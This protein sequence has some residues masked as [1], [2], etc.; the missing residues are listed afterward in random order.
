MEKIKLLFDVFEGDAI[1]NELLH[2]ADM[3]DDGKQ[4][5]N[6]QQFELSA[7]IEGDVNYEDIILNLKNSFETNKR[8]VSFISIRKMNDEPTNE[9]KPYIKEGVRSISNGRRFDLFN[10]MLAEIGYDV[11]VDD[12]LFVTEAKLIIK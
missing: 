2:N 7:E 9:Y 12:D 5:A 10:L 8:N 11:K 4:L 6:Y 3:F 1:Q